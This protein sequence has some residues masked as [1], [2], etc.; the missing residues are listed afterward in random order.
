[1]VVVAI[2]L[3]GIAIGI[4]PDFV[5]DDPAIAMVILV[6]YEVALAMIGF[7]SEIVRDLQGHVRKLVVDYVVRRVW[8]H[9]SHF[10][11]HY[12]DFVLGDL[13]LRV[14]DLN[15]L[16]TV[17]SYTPA[18]DEVFVD[19]NLASQSPNHV[20]GGLLADQSKEVADHR[21]IWDYLDL[22][23]V[24]SLI[25]RGRRVGFLVTAT[26][27]RCACSRVVDE[28]AFRWASLALGLRV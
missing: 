28:R 3:P 16:P 11:R 12:R 18:L 4:W 25:C 14:I 1:W 24:S 8:E 13:S 6:T 22:A 2:G 27:H 7:A 21:S 9:F 19:V 26:P 15:D 10:D 20:P 5:V 17:G 23:M